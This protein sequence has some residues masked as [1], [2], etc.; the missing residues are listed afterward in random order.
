MNSRE[1]QNCQHVV[2]GIAS[3]LIQITSV[4]AGMAI[5]NALPW[6]IPI[7]VGVTTFILI[8]LSSEITY[9]T[10]AALFQEHKR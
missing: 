7:V 5:G 3:L 1:L 6:Y 2:G 8:R 10:N 4:L 9:R